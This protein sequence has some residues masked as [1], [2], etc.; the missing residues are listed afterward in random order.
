MSPAEFGEGN[1]SAILLGWDSYLLLAY[2]FPTT[3][4]SW[5]KVVPNFGKSGGGISIEIYVLRPTVGIQ[6]YLLLQ[7]LETNLVILLGVLLGSEKSKG[8]KL[9]LNP[10]SL[11]IIY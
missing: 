11:F 1:I 8:L 10:G 2:L 5:F 4:E 6:N 9:V 3:V 7:N